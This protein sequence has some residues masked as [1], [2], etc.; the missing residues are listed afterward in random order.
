MTPDAI[1]EIIRLSL[2]ITLKVL[3]TMPPEVAKAA[4]ERHDRRMEFL[5]KLFTKES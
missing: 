3:E 2:L 4:W 5:E 1:L